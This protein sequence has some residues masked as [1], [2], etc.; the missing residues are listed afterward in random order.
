MNC[1]PSTEEHV[2]TDPP[3]QFRAKHILH[4]TEFCNFLDHGRFSESF[5]S[6]GRACFQFFVQ[7]PDGEASG[8]NPL[9]LESAICALCVLFAHASLFPTKSN[10]VLFVLTA[11]WCCF[12][13]RGNDGHS[14]TTNMLPVALLFHTGVR[15]PSRHLSW[16]VGGSRVVVEW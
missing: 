2:R 9:D 5:L 13:P 4:N 12:L 15:R 3:D 11:A 14:T 7:D 1:F 16:F 10:G 8:P 6:A